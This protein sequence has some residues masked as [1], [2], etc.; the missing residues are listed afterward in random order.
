MTVLVLAAVTGHA[1]SLRAYL[2]PDVLDRYRELLLQQQ[3]L[4][5]ANGPLAGHLTLPMSSRRCYRGLPWR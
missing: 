3:G 5:S 1:M 2:A 4:E